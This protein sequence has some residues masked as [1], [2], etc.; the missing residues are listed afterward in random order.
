VLSRR[1]L[2]PSLSALSY[3]PSPNAKVGLGTFE[4]ASRLSLKP[5]LAAGVQLTLGADDPL[6]FGY[7][8]VDEYSLCRRSL[9]PSDE[10]LARVTRYS[11]VASALPPGLRRR[12]TQ[13]VDHWLRAK[14]Q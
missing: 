2:L 6:L 9:G 10:E 14:P 5:M 1:V 12:H 13:G 8:V 11:I 3:P 4:E 7:P